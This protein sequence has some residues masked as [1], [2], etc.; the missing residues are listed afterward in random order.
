MYAI[1]F[2]WSITL[3]LNRDGIETHFKQTA[4]TAMEIRMCTA[5]VRMIY[6]PVPRGTNAFFQRDVYRV[7]IKTGSKRHRWG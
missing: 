5:Y 4:S 1:V 6:G 2:G 7:H 3:F